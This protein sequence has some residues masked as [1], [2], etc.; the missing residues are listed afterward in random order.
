MRLHRLEVY[1]HKGTYKGK[2]N[3]FRLKYINDKEKESEKFFSV[4]NA[5]E[6]PIW[7]EKMR[8]TIKEYRELGKGI[9]V[10]PADRKKPSEADMF[11]RMD[12]DGGSA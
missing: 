2:R 4:E 3:V 9:L 5:E 10:H 7:L 12:M 11:I 8:L 6:Y 1:E